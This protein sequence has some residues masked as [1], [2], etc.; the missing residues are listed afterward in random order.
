II[1]AGMMGA[2]EK[3]PKEEAE[4]LEY[5]KALQDYVN[6]L[7]SEETEKPMPVAAKILR[8]TAFIDLAIMVGLGLVCSA[9]NL[10]LELFKTIAFVTSLIFFLCNG[11][12]MAMIY[13]NEPS[14]D[15]QGE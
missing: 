14:G 12:A 4:E 7:Q 11:I 10:D 6:H 15:I 8:G 13:R 1:L 2:K 5:Q 9:G 3:Y